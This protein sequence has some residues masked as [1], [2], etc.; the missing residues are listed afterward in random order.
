ME[1]S[2]CKFPSAKTLLTEWDHNN[3]S[4]YKFIEAT[5]MGVKGL[6]KN[7]KGEPVEEAEIIVEG[8]NHTIRTTKRGEYWRM[9]TPGKYRITARALR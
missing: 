5:H 9:L 7:S 8:V 1:L 4:L 3:E 2:C 6:V